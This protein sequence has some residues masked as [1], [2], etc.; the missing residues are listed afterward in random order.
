MRQIDI[1][2]QGY[3]AYQVNE[4]ILHNPYSPHGKNYTL[5]LEG[6]YIAKLEKEKENDTNNR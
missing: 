2:E 3:E 5:W 4:L 1:F 6:W